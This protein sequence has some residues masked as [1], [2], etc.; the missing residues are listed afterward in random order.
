MARQIYRQA[1][2]DRLASPEQ[3][4]RP[5]ALASIWGWGA[6]LAL[7]VAILGV[8]VWAL[9]SSAPVKVAARGI[10]LKEGGLVEAVADVGGPIE[11]LEVTTGQSVEAGQPI[12]RFS[13]VELERTLRAKRAE[14]AGAMSRRARLEAFYS[15]QDERERSAEDER[16]ASIAEA[17]VLA[18]RREAMLSKQTEDLAR[19]QG[20]NVVTNVRLMEG[21]LQLASARE[22]LA[23]LDDETKLLALKRL[24]RRSR[25]DLALLDE[26]LKVEALERDVAHLEARLA[27]ERAVRSPAAGRI[28]ELKLNP[29]DVAA[30]GAAVATLEPIDAAGSDAI[31]ILYLQSAVGKRV[32]PGMQAEISPTAFQPAQYGHILGDVVFVSSVPATAAGMRRVLRNE[33][34]A[35]QLAGGTAP[36]EVRVRFRSDPATPSG[37]AWSSSDG[38]PGPVAAGALLDAKIVVARRPI[39]DLVFPGLAGAL[40]LG[41]E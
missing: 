36:F 26:Q 41:G 35:Q 34:L 32:Q 16:L 3:L 30:D 23:E 8:S 1:A 37:L 14:L 22:R 31:A 13:R 19:L 5:H 38:P 25:Y 27:D 18:E 11:A 33:Q 10:V 15:E 24:E 21:E 12:A 4:D 6:V 2:L 7:L 28:V 40:G 9:F 29:G 20:Q 17:Q 39:A